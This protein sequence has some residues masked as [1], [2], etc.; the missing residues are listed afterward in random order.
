MAEIVK[1]YRQSVGATR[2]VG[3]RYTNKDRGPNGMF[4]IRW[5]EWGKNGWFDLLKKQNDGR[6]RGTYEE[7]DAA[8]GL[9]REE[10]GN[11]D[12]F[13][14]WIGFFMPV[15]TAVPEGFQYVDFPPSELGVCW[16]Y[17]KEGEIYGQEAK[18]LER[19]EKEG[20]EITTDWCFERYVSARIDMPDDKGNVII[21][22]CFY[23]K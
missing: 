7:S 10:G 23:I 21:D 18:C 1:A 14:Y 5:E 6:L 8:I 16:L 13:E 11:F 9:M 15:N 17:G 20:F 12:N 3:K 22:I 4:G 2:F 19:L